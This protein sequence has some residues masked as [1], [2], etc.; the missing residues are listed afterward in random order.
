MTLRDS[1][2]EKILNELTNAGIVEQPFAWY[3]LMIGVIAKG[4]E[5]G[6]R[7][8]NG[9]FSNLLNDGQPLSGSIIAV[10]TNQGMDVAEKLKSS[11]EDLFAFPN[12]KVE[13]K[14]RLQ[15]LADLSYG[16][17]LGLTVNAEDGSLE[18]I[19]DYDMKADLNTI[20]EVAKVDLEAELDE[21][22][23]DS[24]VGFMIDVAV[25]NYEI[26]QNQYKTPA[27]AGVFLFV[28]ARHQNQG[29]L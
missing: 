7:V 25:K 16:L 6:S 10:L 9:V 11:S 1:S 20:S 2:Y 14:Q 12:D 28:Q 26:N 22:D 17:S 21:D 19:T 13:K 29:L 4:M 24:V 15:T 18:N 3:S 8:Y 27:R 23:L 5:P